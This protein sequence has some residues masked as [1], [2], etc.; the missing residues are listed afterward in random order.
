VEGLGSAG[1][2]ST[3]A[4]TAILNST[5]TNLHLSDAYIKDDIEKIKKEQVNLFITNSSIN[6][7]LEFQQIQ[8]NNFNNSIRSL[9]NMDVILKPTLAEALNSTTTT[10]NTSYSAAIEDLRKSITQ[11]TVSINEKP[12]QPK[13]SLT[14]KND[15][16]H[17]H[18]CGS[19]NSVDGIYLDSTKIQHKN[20][21]GADSFITFKDGK[22]GINTAAPLNPVEIAGNTAIMGSLYVDGKIEGKFVMDRYAAYAGS[23]NEPAFNFG[24]NDYTGSKT[25]IYYPQDD[26]LAFTTNGVERMRITND[27]VCIPTDLAATTATVKNQ[28][29][30]N[31]IQYENTLKIGTTTT[32]A[33]TKFT[34]ETPLE[35]SNQIT[36]GKSKIIDNDHGLTIRNAD[37][38]IE[39]QK[40]GSVNIGKKLIADQMTAAAID[41]TE[42]L[43][44]NGVTSYSAAAFGYVTKLSEFKGKNIKSVDYSNGLWTITMQ[45]ALPNTHY[46]VV[47]GLCDDSFMGDVLFYDSGIKTTDSFQIK[48]HTNGFA[49]AIKFSFAVFV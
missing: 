16:P 17:I 7:T 20:G 37:S 9:Q 8:N 29:T 24:K 23:A 32:V 18:L 21:Q 36:I 49:S 11:N 6:Q 19:A 34:I 1:Y 15:D 40:D 31:T 42:T 26:T 28:L 2:L 47:V 12:G 38:S 41:I 30:V 3:T 4:F 10:I 46:S 48:T 27:T 35:I 39:L 44:I 14:K 22:I 43:K 33:P 45:E 25:G 5:V 13:I